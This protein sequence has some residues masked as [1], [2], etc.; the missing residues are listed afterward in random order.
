MLTHYIEHGL[1][2]NTRKSA[3][4]FTIIDSKMKLYGGKDSRTLFW[5]SINLWKEYLQNSHQTTYVPDLL[6]QC[7]KDEI[8]SEILRAIGGLGTNG[9]SWTGNN[10]SLY[11]KLVKHIDQSGSITI[12][13][14]LCMFKNYKFELTS[15]EVASLA[16]K[17]QQDYRFPEISAR[18]A[19]KVKSDYLNYCQFKVP[20]R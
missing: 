13:I 14:D 2:P 19:D 15:E 18:L 17:K 11:D 4:V 12:N 5:I 6:S 8:D 3:G 10:Q 1:L 20:K 7:C 16:D 9:K